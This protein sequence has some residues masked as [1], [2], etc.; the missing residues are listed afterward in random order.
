MYRYALLAAFI[1]APAAAQDHAA[2]CRDLKTRRA[3]VGHWASYAWQGGR[4]EGTAMR[5]AIVGTEKVGD[6][7]FYWYEV[8]VTTREPGDR[9]RVIMQALVPG[10]VYDPAGM[11]ALV[12][13]SGKDPAT[14]LPD[15]MVQM[16]AGRS[17]NMAA[18][19]TR[20]CFEAELV[21]WEQVT[22][23]AGVF[24]ALH[25]KTKEGAEAWFAPDL[26]FGLLKVVTKDGDTMVLT[27]QGTDAKSSITERPRPMGGP[28]N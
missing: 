3:T 24:R 20:A 21:G 4:V 15:E 26:L 7:T 9:G 6:S 17:V 23:P 22:V 2:L 13:K 19:M 28:K 12:M 14:R 11:R 10:L 16:M 18:E 1:A 25:A 8:R 5:V 27:G